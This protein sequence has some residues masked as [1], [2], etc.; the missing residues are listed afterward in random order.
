ML[1]TRI[2][3]PN[4]SK[5]S[6]NEETLSTNLGLTGIPGCILTPF[7]AFNTLSFV[8]STTNEHMYPISAYTPYALSNSSLIPLS[9][10]ITNENAS[11]KV[12]SFTPN[13][14]APH[15]ILEKYLASK[16]EILPKMSAII[17]F[18]ASTEPVPAVFTISQNISYISL[19]VISFDV[20]PS[21]SVKYCT[22]SPI[23][24]NSFLFSLILSLSSATLI[25]SFNKDRKLFS[26]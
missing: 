7:N 17:L 26:E 23:S 1:C 13:L 4:L 21:F 24:P 11:N 19:K 8:L 9:C 2:E 22:V 20:Y 6:S 16:G 12:L 15:T 14:R 3:S 25:K 18:L 10:C 5:T